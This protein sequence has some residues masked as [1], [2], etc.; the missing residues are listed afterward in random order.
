MSTPPLGPLGGT[1]LPGHI[2]LFHEGY[3]ELPDRVAALVHPALDDP[4]EGIVLT[5]PPGVARRLRD[6]VER[7]VGVSLQDDAVGR[8]VLL[9]ESERDPDAYLERIRRAIDE[10]M[11]QGMDVVRA[12][13]RVFWN[14]PDFPFPEDHLWLE[15]RLTEVVV[16]RRAIVVCAYDVSE[17]PGAALTYGGLE[18]HPH[19]M[20]DDRVHESPRFLQPDRFLTTRL[21]NLRWLAPEPRAAH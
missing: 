12:I 4:R 2:C 8:R 17:L 21:L 1:P 13:G 9:V 6:D 16:T 14:A 5:G 11:A 10:L 3:A 18:A 15:S 19:L 20:M 7:A